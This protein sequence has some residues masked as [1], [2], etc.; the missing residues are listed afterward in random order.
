MQRASLAI[1][2]MNEKETTDAIYEYKM[3]KLRK[4]LGESTRLMDENRIRISV[5]GG[6]DVK[7]V[8][9]NEK[10]KQD[11]IIQTGQ[12]VQNVAEETI[13]VETKSD[14]KKTDL[15]KTMYA[16]MIQG[17]NL[18]GVA[19]GV[20]ADQNL[21][22]QQ[23][24]NQFMLQSVGNMINSMLSAL[25][26]EEIAKA[27]AGESGLVAKAF[28][29]NPWAAAAIIAAGTAA[30]GAAMG[31][32][33]S[34]ISKSQSQIASATGASSGAGKLATGM[35]TY[36]KGR[37][38]VYADGVYADDGNGRVQGQV[39][40]VRGDDGR[41]YMA[42]Y[43]PQLRTGVVNGPHLGIVGEKGAEL[44]VDHGTYEGLKRYDPETLR[45]IYAMK[46]YGQRSV[47]FG[48][49]A[50]T[51]NE[52]LLNRSGVRR[53]ADGNVEDVLARNGAGDG[54]AEGMMAGMQETLSELTA[55]LAA[56]KAEGIQAH[57]G[58]LGSSG[59]KSTMDKG[60]RFLRRVGKG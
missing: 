33:K 37:Y 34:Q 35:L 21:N 27:A 29:T 8:Q 36:A 15:A 25:L 11:S 38:P 43:Q 12:T 51:G 42:K 23:K 55:V 48:R 40:S 32:M 22:T 5:A 1:Q 13:Q 57:M 59:A 31:L 30:I 53:Y 19:Y 9:E 18:Y 16:A 4:Y 45:R 49:A 47:D 46:M 2:E 54:G 10:T 26:A 6:E 14:K 17:A 52:V 41:D 44:I 58:Y 60:D 20:V 24:V 3:D 50:R 56:V 39:V 7:R 28:G